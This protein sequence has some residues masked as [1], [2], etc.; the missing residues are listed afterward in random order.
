MSS[1]NPFDRLAGHYD[2]MSLGISGTAIAQWRD[3]AADMLLVPEGGAVL[4]VG[5]GTGVGTIRLAER[6]GVTGRVVGLDPSEAMLTEARRRRLSPGAAP[7]AWTLG[8]GERLPFADKTFDRVIAQF[9]LRHMSDWRQGLSEMARVTADDGRLVVVDLVRPVSVAGR[10]ALRAMQLAVAPL[11]LPQWRPY[12]SLVDTLP[13]GPA[14][15]D[16]VE[17]LGPLG[18]RT[19]GERRWIGDLVTALVWTGPAAA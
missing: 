1:S 15:R 2:C 9:T 19:A 8:Q 7:V 10:I 14:A 11:V 16:L 18:W 13:E 3:R 5:C 17:H 4:D 12:R 6:A